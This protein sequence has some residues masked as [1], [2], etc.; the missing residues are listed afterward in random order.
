MKKE[1]LNRIKEVFK[2][3]PNEDKLIITSDGH[4]FLHNALSLAIDHAR[5]NGL[6]YDI[7]HRNE[8]NKSQEN[9]E[10]KEQK[11]PTEKKTKK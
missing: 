5:R 10:S 3:Y 6:E 2:S 8:L 7:I 1:H 11:E 9:V 4:I